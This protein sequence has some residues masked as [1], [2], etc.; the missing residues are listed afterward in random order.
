MSPYFSDPD[1]DRLTYSAQSDNTSVARVSVS[2][3]HNS[4]VT[5]TP[6]GEGSARM[7]VIAADP[8][9]LTATQIIDV[10]VQAAHRCEYTLSQS[11]LEVPAAGRPHFR[12]M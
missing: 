11:S 6:R 2:G 4:V 10:T 9:G 12:L 7:T 5:I 8:G 3:S 1:N